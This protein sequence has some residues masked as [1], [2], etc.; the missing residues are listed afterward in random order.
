MA[1]GAVLT[2]GPVGIV[3]PGLFLLIFAALCRNAVYG[4]RIF[5]PWGIFIFFI[6]ALPWYG[7]MYNL[8]GSQ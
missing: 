5:N 2:K 1:A 8:H 4:K 6:L 7:I 3:L